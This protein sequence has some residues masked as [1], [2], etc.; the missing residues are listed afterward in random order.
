MSI[1]TTH[2]KGDTTFNDITYKWFY[3]YMTL[4]ITTILT[5]HYKGDITF[6]DITYDWF[7]L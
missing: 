6:N 5:T 1:L 2:D 4:L 3:L 7:Y